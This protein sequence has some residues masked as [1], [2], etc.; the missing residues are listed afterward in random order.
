MAFLKGLNLGNA[1]PHLAEGPQGPVL[2]H[3]VDA[4]T[5]DPQVEALTV[6]A[7]T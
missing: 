1:V 3:D 6:V 7:V 5:S 2:H 4:D